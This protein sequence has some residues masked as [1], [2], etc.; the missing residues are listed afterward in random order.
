MTALIWII[1][2]DRHKAHLIGHLGHQVCGN[3]AEKYHEAPP[4]WNP[5]EHLNQCCKSCLRWYIEMYHKGPVPDAA[6]RYLRNVPEP[7]RA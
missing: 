3:I 5:F 4:D 7:V 2:D 1:S 6:W